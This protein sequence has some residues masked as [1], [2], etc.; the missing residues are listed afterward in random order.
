M[1]CMGSNT[2]LLRA[3]GAASSLIVQ[4]RQVGPAHSP[5]VEFTLDAHI[6]EVQIKVIDQ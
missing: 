1:I 4:F 3:H 6:S 2:E 5:K